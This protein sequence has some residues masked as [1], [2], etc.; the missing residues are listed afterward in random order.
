MKTRLHAG[1]RRVFA[2][3]SY[4]CFSMSI[5]IQTVLAD[6]F[7]QVDLSEESL[8]SRIFVQAR[9]A[10]LVGAS[11]SVIQDIRF[12]I[13]E[14]EPEPVVIVANALGGDSYSLTINLRP[15]NENSDDYLMRLVLHAP[16][17]G[18][19]KRRSRRDSSAHADFYQDFYNHLDKAY[20]RERTI[21]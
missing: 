18:G 9:L 1:I 6:E 8:Q 10:D 17:L 15:T 2:L 14:T 4:C 3:I 13:V 21:Q 12:H 20:F 5:T 16:V 7:D 11:I 19:V